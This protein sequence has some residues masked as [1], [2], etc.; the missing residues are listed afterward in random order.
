MNADGT[1]EEVCSVCGKPAAGQPFTH[2]YHA[3]KRFNLCCPMCVQMFQR[4][5]DRF[6][7]GERP[8]TILQDL[9]NEL[10]WRDP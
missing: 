10:K 1:S 9:L 2:L 4:A 3:G 6:A 5:P 8:Q 7:R